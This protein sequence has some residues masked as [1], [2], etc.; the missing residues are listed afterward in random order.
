M[1]LAVTGR[2]EQEPV[3]SI[4]VAPKHLSAGIGILPKRLKMP[5]KLINA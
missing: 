3:P 5:K 1:S 4:A 2:C